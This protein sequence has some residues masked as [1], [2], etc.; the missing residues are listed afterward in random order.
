MEGGPWT[1]SEYWVRSGL[2]VLDL[3]LEREL[4]PRWLLVRMGLDLPLEP[5]PGRARPVWWAESLPKNMIA[6]ESG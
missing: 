2:L 5:L 6:V 4:E 3:D 1:E